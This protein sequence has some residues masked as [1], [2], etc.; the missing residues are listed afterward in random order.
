M[1]KNASHIVISALLLLVPSQLIAGGPPWL[2]LPIDGVTLDNERACI[3]LLTAK[4]GG[5]TWPHAGSRSREIQIHQ[6]KTQSYLTFYM[7]KDVGLAEVE[8]ALKGSR[9]SVPR[10]KL[11]LFGHAIL[12][13]DT[14]TAPSKEMLADLEA[15]NFVSVAK[16]EEKNG[17]FEVTIDMPYPM[18]G[19]RPQP[20][21]IGWET[22]T[23]NDFAS[24]QSTKS[25]PPASPRQLPAYSDFHKIVSKHKGKLK[26]IRWDTYYACRPLGAAAS[27]TSNDVADASSTKPSAS[28]D[29]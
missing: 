8:S 15:L 27:S 11:R 1:L 3:E 14:R 26:D 6:F 20:E 23:R 25:E 17:H 28:Y 29:E 24:D 22:F 16:S 7:G 2:Y 9:F 10:D 13:I 21:S 12:E 19:A 18:I 4:L 5:K